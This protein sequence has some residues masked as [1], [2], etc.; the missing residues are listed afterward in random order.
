MPPTAVYP[1]GLIEFG[2]KGEPFTSFASSR[3]I[4]VTMITNAWKRLRS[5]PI[6]VI[7]APA[8]LSVREFVSLASTDG[9]AGAQMKRHSIAPHATLTGES[10]FR[11]ADHAATS[12]THS[13]ICTR[14]DCRRR[15]DSH[16]GA[17]VHFS[18]R[19]P[20]QCLSRLLKRMSAGKLLLVLG[21]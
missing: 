5:F 8:L 20:L 13:C 10:S 18:N 12:T 17:G 16:C 3:A 9:K 7:R 6:P 14:M 1:V 19:L 4:R 15:S 11:D 2:K 21:V